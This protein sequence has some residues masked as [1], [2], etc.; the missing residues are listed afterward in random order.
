[1]KERIERFVSEQ[2]LDVRT[3]II[4]DFDM[5]LYVVAKHNQENVAELGRI[6]AELLPTL[7]LEPFFLH[8]NDNNLSLAP[9]FLGKERA[10]RWVIDRRLGLEPCM[11]IGVGDS[12]TDAAFLW[13]CDYA[14]TP[15]HSQ[16]ARCWRG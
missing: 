7:D 12:Q 16:L 8:F 15:R 9:K 5:P 10:V 14:L 6:A 13:E 4:S 2:R 3:R 1:M 11:T